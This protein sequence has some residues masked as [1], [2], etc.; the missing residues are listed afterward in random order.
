M[1]HSI[2]LIED[3]TDILQ[4]VKKANIMNMLEN[5]SIYSDKGIIIKLSINLA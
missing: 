3:I 1:G 5:F 2:A 4:A